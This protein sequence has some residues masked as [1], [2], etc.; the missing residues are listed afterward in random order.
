MAETIEIPEGV[1]VPGDILMIEFEITSTNRTLV[2]M[3]VSDIK[4][5]VWADDRLDY[6]GSKEFTVG[7]LELQRDVTILQVFAS[8]RK[9]RRAQRETMQYAITG[10]A[11]ATI[12]AAIVGSVA[13]LAAGS[14]I[15]R[16]YTVKKV[17]MSDQ[18]D[19]VKIAALDAMDKPMFDLSRIG[20]GTLAVGAL[21]AWALF[22][23]QRR[24][25]GD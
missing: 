4:K 16:S 9:Y 22:G 13:A 19:A 25:M 21:F 24:I 3:V 23:R 6:Q 15:Y 14:V 18:S 17:A 5:N 1:L 20:V 10:A 2:G 7:D 11:A 12:V 8:V